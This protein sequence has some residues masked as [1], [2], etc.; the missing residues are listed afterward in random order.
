M[1]KAVLEGLKLKQVELTVVSAVLDSGKSSGRLRKEYGMI[2]PGDLR[3]AFLVLCN[4]GEDD[5]EILDCRFPEGELA[6]HNLWNIIFTAAFLKYGSY[7]AIFERINSYLLGTHRILPS[8]IHESDLVAI[9]ENGQEI[10]GESNIDVPKHDTSLKIKEV[11]LRPLVKACPQTI[12][13][14]GLADLV[15]IGPGDIY[16]SLMQVL[17]VDGTHQAIKASK[18]KK[19]YV[20]NAMTK[21]GES[22]G[23]KAE[24]F[25][26]IVEERLDCELDYVIY[27]NKL[28][29][30]S[31]VDKYREANPQFLELVDC[32]GLPK[33]KK[34]I[35]TDLLSAEGDIVYDTEKL[36]KIL[37]S[38]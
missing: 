35:G 23:F 13:R 10:V 38:L 21:D 25:I 14:I 34:H 26:R 37:L 20:C 1:P 12:R 16:S 2:S 29:S 6:E 15:V 18:A 5:K 3:R 9:L 28:P 27:N 22:N 4:L 19:V 11:F 32:S 33:T 36:A 7:R 24:D 17:L 31:R 8:T 30:E